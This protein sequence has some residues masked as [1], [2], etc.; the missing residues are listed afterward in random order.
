MRRFSNAL[1]GAAASIFDIE[2]TDADRIVERLRPYRLTRLL[3]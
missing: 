2:P 3:G 1:V